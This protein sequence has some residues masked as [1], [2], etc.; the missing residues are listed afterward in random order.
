LFNGCRAVGEVGCL[1]D[2]FSVL[3]RADGPALNRELALRDNPTRRFFHHL[4]EQHAEVSVFPIIGRRD[5]SDAV[6][7]RRKL[8]AFLETDALRIIRI[9]NRNRL[10]TVFFSSP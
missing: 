2:Q 6:G 8:I 1:A 5:V 10:S 3:G 7:V 9:V 4:F